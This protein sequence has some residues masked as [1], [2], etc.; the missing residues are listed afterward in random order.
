MKCENLLCRVIFQ[1]SMLPLMSHRV[2]RKR[3]FRSDHRFKSFL[4]D[5]PYLI[6]DRY[7][8]IDP[9][10]RSTNALLDSTFRASI[11]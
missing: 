5:D 11:H 10:I 8:D 2:T 6:D 9:F 3:F 7:L 1:Y 4:I